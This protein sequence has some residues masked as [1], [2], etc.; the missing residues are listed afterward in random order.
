MQPIK[1]IIFYILQLESRLVLKKYKPEIIV[2]T[3][4]VGKTSTKD[5]IF[6]VVRV[7]GSAG[8]SQK[9]YNSEIGIPL[10]ILGRN[11]SWQSL[12]GWLGSVIAGL[13]LILFKNEYPSIL[14]LEAGAD[15]PGDIEKISQLLKPHIAVVCAI[16]EVPVHVEFFVGPKELAREKAKILA[17][18]QAADFAILNFDDLAVLEMRRDV[19]CHVLTFGFGEGA[20][21]RATDYKIMY[22]REGDLSRPEGIT[23]KV[24]YNGAVVPI[25]V[26]ETFGK[27]QVYAALGAAAVGVAKGINLVQISEALS[28]YRAPAGRLRTI[29][30]IK[31]SWI[32]D[33]SYNASPQAMHAALDLLRE[34]P[35]KRKIAVLGDMLEL[36]EYTELAHRAV[37]EHLHGVDILITVGFRAKFVADEARK[38]AFSSG[39]ILEFHM[40]GEVT[41]EL[42]KIIEPGDLILIKGSQAMRMEKITAAV[43]AHPEKAGELLVRQEEEWKNR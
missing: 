31:Y 7:L 28:R 32:L 33:D 43:M 12:F 6:E 40:S 4:N 20:D 19:K 41:E 36:G 26:F 1:K 15:H 2:I 17:G 35:A 25:R 37:G 39:K 14:V 34:F 9:S 10:A 11:T 38:N 42:K 30:G 5:A 27:P 3:G 29:P 8:K 22:E 18:L 16:G 21:I 23:F 24:N 13:K